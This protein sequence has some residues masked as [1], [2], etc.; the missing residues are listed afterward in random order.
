MPKFAEPG[1]PLSGEPA[2][3]T[4]PR[5]SRCAN[6][7]RDHQRPPTPPGHACRPGMS[8]TSLPAS[9]APIVS[10]RSSGPV[11]STSPP[12]TTGSGNA[13]AACVTPAVPG[14]RTPADQP[15]APRAGRDPTPPS[16]TR[17]SP[18]ATTASRSRS[19]TTTATHQPHE[20]SR[21]AGQQAAHMRVGSVSNRGSAT[22]AGVEHRQRCRAPVPRTG[23]H[24]TLRSEA[25]RIGPSSSR[26]SVAG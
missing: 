11:R 25:P 24:S 19:A 13:I 20:S 4:P 3:T 21:W 26:Q 18:D 5:P 14:G 7:K 2:R 10:T 15:A 1:R 8:P 12:D 16:R 17:R 9:S 22:L 23:P 6:H